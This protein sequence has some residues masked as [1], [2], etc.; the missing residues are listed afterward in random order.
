[1]SI[2]LNDA[3][4]I[5]HGY[6]RMYIYQVNVELYITLTK[7]YLVVIHVKCKSFIV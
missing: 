5:A 7:L 4:S 6:V 3:K 2:K 1:V